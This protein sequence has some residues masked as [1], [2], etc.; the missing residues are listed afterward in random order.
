MKIDEH[1][2]AVAARPRRGAGEVD[3][4][5]TQRQLEIEGRIEGRIEGQIDGGGPVLEAVV[6]TLDP[7]RP[8]SQALC[9]VL[10]SGGAGDGGGGDGG[11]GDR[12]VPLD[13]SQTMVLVPGERLASSLSRALLGRAGALGQPLFAPTVVTPKRFGPTFV[14]P[15]ATVL[16]DVAAL[17]SWR[18]VLERSIVAKDGFA[19]RVAALFGVPGE[20]DARVRMQIV[21]RI[22][23][24]SNE[25]A[26]A[27][28][29][30][31][32]IASSEAVKV[33]RDVGPK[34]EVLAEFARRRADLL[35]SAGVAD[36][37]EAIR[38]AVKHGRILHEGIRRLVV[39]L[40]DPEPVQRALLR[41]LRGR[42]VRVEVCVHC[43]ESLDDEGFP[44]A[45]AWERRAFPISRIPSES[46]RVATSPNVAADAAVDAIRAISRSNGA[47]LG[48]DD[49]FVMAPD[50]ETRR[51]LER[52][53][54]RVATP[55]A[56]G[57]SR[58]F[59]AT[60]L[61]A[62]LAR[63]AALLGEGSVEALAAFVRHD[64]VARWLNPKLK[65]LAARDA[66]KRGDADPA[67]VSCDAGDRVSAYRG[68]T[69]VSAWRDEPVAVVE[70]E[71]RES[72]GTAKEYAQVR[73]AVLELCGPLDG[74]RPAAEWAKPLRAM[75]ETII[76]E[77]LSGAHAEERAST[78][79]ALDRELGELHALP[80]A[81]GAPVGA[82]EAIE[83]VLARL[84]S[85]EVRGARIADGVTIAGW[86]DAGMADEPHLVLAGFAEGR[87]P[88]GAV[89]DP[90]LPEGVRSALGMMSGT[91]R[92]ARDAWILD[93]ILLRTAARAAGGL[94][95]SVSFIVPQ[96]SEEGDPLKPSRFLLRVEDAALPDR[97][98]LL[99][100]TSHR[101]ERPRIESAGE[102]RAMFERTP[103]IDGVKIESMS[104]T[105]FRSF[106]QCPYLFQLQHDARLGL[107]AIEERLVEL[108]ARGFGNL[109]HS[110]LEK[111]GREE[112]AAG[113]RTEDPAVIER[114]VSRHLDELVAR[115]YP[116]SRAPAL[117][118]QVE[119]ARRRLR[120]FAQIQAEEA[121]KGWKV[122]LVECS[123]SKSPT[124]HGIQ[125]PKIPQ[126]DGLYLTGR[127]D[128][129]DVCEATG[130]FRA[131]DYKTSAKGDSPTSVH[132]RRRKSD[133]GTTRDEWVDLQLPLY[134][135]LLRSMSPR[136][137]V[138]A[139]ELGYLNL[140]PTAEK[141]K[142][143]LLD[144]ARVTEELLDE[145]EAL[146][147]D[148]VRRVLAGDFT[149][150]ER[151]PVGPD[152]PLAPIWGLGQ[153]GLAEED[154]SGGGSFARLEGG[155]S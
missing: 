85:Q 6:R 100:P 128:R 4:G 89:A 84:S 91:R 13:F 51:A 140:A 29:S 125:A 24:L 65:D 155:E 144:G 44:L 127:I 52:A 45:A 111:W 61:G 143:S 15:M 119:L 16:S 34:F 40:A 148:I 83:L 22:A 26:A 63:L 141:S 87:V 95:A 107:S 62:L 64:D 74:M 5:D 145:A 76:G 97:V 2:Y 46:I 105:S 108:D 56:V 58:A 152:D 21:R 36:R 136:I 42:G 139:A 80:K 27:M 30:F 114:E 33:R 70:G 129:V 19:A 53:F 37:D 60:R 102:A 48:S 138:G 149:P 69:L 137:D 130:R 68:K 18:E 133:D 116:R 112:I 78:I 41:L 88:E 90:L 72:F 54:A 57:D 28:Q 59:A 120:R 109:L 96:Q 110:A 25:A 150:S 146:A 93:G 71:R 121:Q 132:L 124:T 43:S 55:A 73:S 135:V 32:S 31:E 77:D 20:P 7:A 147:Q 81:F 75:L 134:R 23:R 106:L 101:E 118:V 82:H 35:A 98:T 12:A 103:K 47:T 154:A 10:V 113:R 99:F 153:R 117:R 131:L 115:H 11:G 38:D 9:E 1:R 94:G 8:L 123:F 126:P 151:I 86:L 122:H 104:V 50:D 92:A 49:L 17:C 14:E 66:A 142:V 39:L 67:A 3:M 79:R